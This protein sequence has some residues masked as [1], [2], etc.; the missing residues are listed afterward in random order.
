MRR[1][2]TTTITCKKRK[3]EE[4]ELPLCLNK[5]CL[6]KGGKHYIRDFT[7]SD[8]A[9]K[10]ILR[11]EHGSAKSTCNLTSRSTSIII[12]ETKKVNYASTENEAKISA[13][14]KAKP[15]IGNVHTEGLA[16]IQSGMSLISLTI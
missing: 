8:E 10:E 12:P 6:Y 13:L 14:Y 4:L 7:M 16:S 2:K 9:T 5:I 11:Q 1:N 15:G 3:R